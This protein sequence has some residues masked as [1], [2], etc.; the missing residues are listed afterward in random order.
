[1]PITHITPDELKQM[2]RGTP[3]LQLVDVRTPDEF[4][5]LGHISQARL[6]PLSEL[7]Y[8]FRALDPR[9]AVVVTCQ[10]GI[11]SLD[12]CYF[13]Q[14]QGFDTLFNLED[15]ASWTGPVERE[16]LPSQQF[17]NPSTQG[18]L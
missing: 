4:A 17:V 3:G 12:A 14:A 10:H 1:M 8:A 16:T 15:M 7:P 9:E 13:L 11:R 6:I 18:D 5:Y 2:L